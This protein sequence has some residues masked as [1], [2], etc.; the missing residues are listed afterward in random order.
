MCCRW[1]KQKH[2]VQGSGR[3]FSTNND[4]VVD[5][6]SVFHVF[7]S[8]VFNDSS[9]CKLD[10]FTY[11]KVGQPEGKSLTLGFEF[12]LFLGE[13]IMITHESYL[14]VGFLYLLQ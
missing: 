6:I 1:T 10:P 7:E 2:A 3:D 14:T 13:N 9:E 12:G 4:C 5:T 11:L 8:N